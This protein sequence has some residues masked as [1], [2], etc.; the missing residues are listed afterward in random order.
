MDRDAELFTA[1][2]GVWSGP[3]EIV[4]GKYKGTKFTCNLTG[5]TPDGKVGMSLD[6]SCRVGVFTQPMSASVERRGGAYRGA[7][8][9]GAAGKGLDITNGS[10]NA[11]RAV[12]SINRKELKGAMLAKLNGRDAMNVTIS[13]RVDNRLVPVIGM[14]LKR[15]DDVATG[16]VAN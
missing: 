9:D 8:L 6:G 1:I 14:N 4:A 2:K 16:S 12:F 5:V 11:Q 13:V 10:I 7:F 3:G 15:V